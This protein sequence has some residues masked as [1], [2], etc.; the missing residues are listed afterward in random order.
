[1]NK[2]QRN[3]HSGASSLQAGEY[4]SR[5]LVETVHILQGHTDT[6]NQCDQ[7]SAIATHNP[8]LLEGGEDAGLLRRPESC[9]GLLDEKQLSF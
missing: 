9:I 1:M 4:D 2:D 8:S 6:T 7:P 5:T 3:A